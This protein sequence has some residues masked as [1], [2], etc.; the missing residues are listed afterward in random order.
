M[1]NVIILCA[2]PQ[3]QQPLACNSS[4]AGQAVQCPRC[5][6]LTAVGDV[7]QDGFPGGIRLGQYTIV[8]KIGQGGMGRVYEALQDGLGRRVALKVPRVTLSMDPRFF[9]RFLRE[10]QI[11]ATLNHRNIVQV[12]EVG[13]DKGYPFFSMELVEG[14]TLQARLARET[15][16]PPAVALEFLFQSVRGLAHAGQHR[17]VHRDIKPGNLILALDGTLKITDFGLARAQGSGQQTSQIVGGTAT[18]MSPEQAWCQKNLDIRSDIYSLGASFYHALAGHVPFQ[19]RT[20]AETISLAARGLRRP[21]DEIQPDVS[22]RLAQI[23]EKMMNRDAAERYQTPTEI[24]VDLDQLKALEFPPNPTSK[25]SAPSAGDFRPR[26]PPPSRR[27]PACLRSSARPESGARPAAVRSPAEKRQ[28]IAAWTLG[29]LIA[30]AGALFWVLHRARPESGPGPTLERLP[31]TRPEEDYRL[32]NSTH[33]RPEPVPEEKP[34]QAP[35][36]PSRGVQVDSDSVAGSDAKRTEES[37]LESAVII[38]RWPAQRDS[39]KPE[40]RAQEAAAADA[41]AA[42]AKPS[43]ASVP[44]L[45]AVEDVS[46]PPDEFPEDQAEAF[47]RMED[48]LTPLLKTHEHASAWEE[49][50]RLALRPENARFRD[51]LSAMKQDFEA[52]EALWQ[53]FLQAME[54]AKGTEEIFNIRRGRLAGARDGLLLLEINS[55]TERLAPADVGPGK[56]QEKLQISPAR[57]PAETCHALAAFW[58]H[59]GRKDK[60]RELLEGIGGSHPD[61]SRLLQWL[62]W[63]REAEATQMIRAIQADQAGRNFDAVLKRVSDL[64]RDFEDTRAVTRRKSDLEQLRAGAEAAILKEKEKVQAAL[65]RLEVLVQQVQKERERWYDDMKEKVKQQ[66]EKEST[67]PET[68]VRRGDAEFGH[69]VEHAACPKSDNL[70]TLKTILENM[71]RVTQFVQDVQNRKIEY[72]KMIEQLEKEIDQAKKNYQAGLAKLETLY[73]EKRR[74]LKNREGRVA[75]RI[76]EGINLTNEE[77]LRELRG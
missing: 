68:Y 22:P 18:Y 63:S 13:N 48:S 23:V 37:P 29:V 24:L 30:M 10:A 31:A 44:P 76:R 41:V 64:L 65:E 49:V 51:D 74:S 9:K 62:R 7:G 59:E 50:Q 60:A 12:Y 72:K 32:Q 8:R 6:T 45:P 35:N 47:G 39:W 15:R 3:C 67:D 33:S 20:A 46:L 71:P 34:Q 56:I 25:A 11:A 57:S 77:I 40:A 27:A 28:Q 54:A 21:L 1:S 75:R 26:D 42:E 5:G 16:L 70:K 55:R 43:P 58:L 38:P 66:Y 14:E 19:G 52:V 17:V 2:N 73:K 4:L 61:A 69:Y 36:A 53:Q